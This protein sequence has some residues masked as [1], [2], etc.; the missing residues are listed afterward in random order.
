METSELMGLRGKLD[1]FVAEFDDCIKTRPSREHARTYVNGLLGPLER[2]NVEAIAL[3][4]GTPVRTLQEFLST[5][6]WDDEAVARRVRELVRVRHASDDAVGVVDETSFAKKGK[7]TAGVKR[8]HCGSTG[9]IENCVVTV[10]LGYV[11]NDLHALLD[12]ELFV[13]EEWAADAERCCE[14]GLPETTTHRPKTKIAVDLVRRAV[15][16]GV[17]LRWITADEAYG[18]ATEFRD[19]VAGLGLQYAVEIP[20]SLKGWTRKPRVEPAGMKPKRG[21]PRKHARLAANASKSRPVEKLWKRGGPSWQLFRIKDTEK[22]PEVWRVRETRFYPWRREGS[23]GIPGDECRLVIAQNVLTEER[24]YF[25]TNATKDTP[26]TKILAVVFSRGHV[27]QLFREG[28]GAVG[29]DHFQ[30]RKHIALR[31]HLVMTAVAVLFLAEQTNRL[32]EKKSVVDPVSGPGGRR[33]TA[34]PRHDTVG[35]PP[36]GREGPSSC[37]VLA[38][39]RS[40]GSQGSHKATEAGASSRRRQPTPNPAL[41]ASPGEAQP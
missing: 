16:E 1:E 41:P 38:A 11:A 32:R 33:G 36:S 27:E 23:E 22:G 3:E 5:R 29:L 34:R 37:D 24:K 20:R 35:T 30:V 2:K 17:H 39:A 14:A 26:L 18:R 25:L 13:P 28:K 7:R 8:Q 19:S 4:A 9:K 15:E 10:H 21:R 6:L 12:S 31:R 40:S